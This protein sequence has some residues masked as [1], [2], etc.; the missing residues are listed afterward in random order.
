MN[1]HFRKSV[2]DVL[3]T[4]LTQRCHILLT[5]V[6]EP[7]C[8]LHERNEVRWHPGQEASLAPPCSKLRYFGSKCTVL[9]EV[10]VTLLGLFGAPTV[11]RRLGNCA[12]LRP[13]MRVVYSCANDI[14]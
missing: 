5:R 10:L 12:S 6:R 2:Y 14:S 4:E 3:G 11:T 13:C 8:A 1:F 9:K 7:F